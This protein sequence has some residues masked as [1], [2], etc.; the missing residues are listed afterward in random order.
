MEG[1]RCI[2][3]DCDLE[4]VDQLPISDEIKY[5]SNAT[6]WPEGVVPESGDV[7]ILP[8]ENIIFDLEDT[9]VFDLITVN[10]QLSFLDEPAKLPKLNLNCKHMFVRVGN[11][12]IGTEDAPFTA[13][14]QI[15][16]HG[17]KSDAQ[18]KMSGAVEA[19]NKII[20]NTNLVEFHGQSR[21]RM[22]RLEQPIEKGMTSTLVAQG[23]DWVAGDK[24]YFAPTNV[25]WQH[26][27]YREIASYLPE[28][29]LLKVTEAFDFYHYGGIDISANY[30]GLD[31]RGEVVLL[32]R[33]VRIVGDDANSW[34]CSTV[35]TDRVEADRSVRVGKMLLNNV[36]LHR[37]GQEDTF[38]S[39]IR[40]ERSQLGSYVSEV[41][42]SVVWG[43][44]AK[45]L[46]IKTSKNIKITD[47]AFIGAK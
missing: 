6:T 3:I 1:I 26:S 9:P 22:S 2:N 47:S 23:L 43:G 7:E 24:L 32:S 42:N 27:E 25:H 30:E 33:N 34:G 12:L 8:G 46:I 5:W 40:F 39:A 28:T 41:K 15:T 19:G 44:N 17:R 4:Q 38:K 45:N 29:G 14:A 13:D 18:I 31:M 11:L 37:C 16:L 21:D 10:G 36:E 35:T 20:A